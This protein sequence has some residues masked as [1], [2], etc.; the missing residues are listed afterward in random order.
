[1]RASD[2]NQFDSPAMAKRLS[3]VQKDV[4]A[5]FRRVLRAAV[6]KDREVAQLAQERESLAERPGRPSVGALLQSSSSST[7]YASKEFR[8]QA[9]ETKRSDF[10]KIE[11]MLRKADKQ[12]KLL[13]MPGVK[14]V[15][16]TSH[17][18]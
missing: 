4:L 5:C 15:T 14:I 13:S 11:Y 3:G 12:I 1:M 16:G 8:R 6:S 17:K 10:K 18:I 7:S 9:A 2:I